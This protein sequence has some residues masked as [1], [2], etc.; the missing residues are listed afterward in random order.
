MGMVV[1]VRAVG[2]GS[3]PTGRGD[4]RRT[5]RRQTR[6]GRSVD[7][8][9]LEDETVKAVMVGKAARQNRTWPSM[10]CGAEDKG[11]RRRTWGRRKKVGGGRH[12][13]RRDG[14]Q[15]SVTAIGRSDQVAGAVWACAGHWMV[16]GR[17]RAD[18]AGP[19][20]GLLIRVTLFKW[21]GQSNFDYSFSNISIS[22]SLK[23]QNMY[24]LFSKKFQTFLRPR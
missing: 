22:S 17:P 2:R 16:R 15:G 3:R 5:R 6:P 14:S 8:E 23:I 4:A 9:A 11:A 18:Y 24:S 21:P 1:R 13:A 12:S 19:V 20:A 10:A 7:A